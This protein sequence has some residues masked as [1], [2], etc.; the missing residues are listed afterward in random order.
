MVTAFH[1]LLGYW[2]VMEFQCYA[3]SWQ[4]RLWKTK[5]S[6]CQKNDSIEERVS[7]EDFV[8][9]NSLPRLAVLKAV[10]SL[11]PVALGEV[12]Q[13]PWTRWPKENMREMEVNNSVLREQLWDTSVMN[14]V[15]WDRRIS[16]SLH[17]CFLLV[18]ELN[19]ENTHL[20]ASVHTFLPG[21]NNVIVYLRHYSD[22]LEK[23]RMNQYPL[24]IKPW[25]SRRQ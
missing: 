23:G 10:Y 12:D 25:C 20:L 21:Y 5:V 17:F 24:Y 19:F 16:S 14:Q 6:Q 11:C 3:K 9:Q 13:L 22:S 7:D 15:A 1:T 4:G 2:I 18:N 8:T